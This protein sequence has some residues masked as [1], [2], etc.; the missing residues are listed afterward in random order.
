[1]CTIQYVH[2]TRRLVGRPGGQRLRSLDHGVM[3]RQSV[4]RT[5]SVQIFI[6]YSVFFLQIFFFRAEPVRIKN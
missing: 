2:A 4:I 3:F 1:M 5:G 6:H